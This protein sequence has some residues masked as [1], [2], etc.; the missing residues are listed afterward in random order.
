[1]ANQEHLD[2]LEE[3]VKVWNQWRNEHP[4]IRPDLRGADLRWNDLR[5]VHLREADLSG[6]KFFRADLGRAD[7][8]EANIRVT[9]LS[10]ANLHQSVLM[11]ADLRGA[12]LSE[13]NLIGANLREA[14][15]INASLYKAKLSQA[16]LSGTNLERANLGEVDLSEANLSEAM[17]MNTNM[18]HANL[19]GTNLKGADLILV[20]LDGA[21][22]SRANLSNATLTETLLSGADL[23][24]AILS[25]ATLNMTDLKGANLRE[26]IVGSTIFVD[27]DLSLAEEL[28]S[29]I[30]E[31]PSSIGIDTIYRSKGHIPEVFLRGVG[32]PDSFLE[33][34]P[35]IVNR[36]IEYYTCFISYSSK[37]QDFAQRLYA[38]LQSKGVRCWFAPEDMKIGDQIR[39]RI[40]EAIRINDKLLLIISE[41]SVE[42]EWVEKEVETAFEREHQQ[43]RLVLFPIRLDDSVMKA[44]QAWAADIRRMRHIGDF[45]RWK[46]HDDYQKAFSR[47][48]RDLIAGDTDERGSME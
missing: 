3:G 44:P 24:K 1:M 38:D 43:N 9:D 26:V 30:H 6:V 41:H 31:F 29:V 39:S 40:D 19:G 27:I 5:D 12:I 22:L 21:D 10:E 34:M 4:D 25:F 23:N 11:R 28:E 15:L 8:R 36:P 7:L 45:T 47:L 2:I 14:N 42:S 32:V 46:N 16:D 37:D 18:F 17:L 48:M 33:I 13:A 20:N 35:S